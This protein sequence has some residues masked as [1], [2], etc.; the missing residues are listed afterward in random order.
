M[1]ILNVIYVIA[2]VLVL[3]GAAILSM[4]SAISGSREGWA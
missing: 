1:T 2:A 3:F 4:N